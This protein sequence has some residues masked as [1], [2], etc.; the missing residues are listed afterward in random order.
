MNAIREMNLRR[1]GARA[2]AAAILILVA[3]A[4]AAADTVEI[5]NLGISAVGAPVLLDGGRMVMVVPEANEGRDL[6]GDGDLTDTVFHLHEIATG[7]TTNLGLAGRSAVA[8]EGGAVALEIFESRQGVDLNGD[9]DTFDTVIHIHDPATG[10]TT[11]LGIAGGN[12][13]RLDGGLLAF[14]ASESGEGED[15]NGDGDTSDVVVHLHDPA[16]GTTTN[17]GIA[18]STLRALDGGGLAFYADSRVHVHDPATGAT[19]DVGIAAIELVALDDGSVAFAAL[20]SEEG[21]LNGD[22][23]ADDAVPHR[24]DPATAT[25]TNLGV[26]GRFLVALDGGKLM[27]RATESQQGVDWNGD[28]DTDDFVV[29]VHHPGST[30]TTNVGIA[31]ALG[32]DHDTHVPLEQGRLAFWASESRH[33]GDLNGD[34]DSS[35]DV[36]HVHDPSTGITAS[37][38]I[39]SAIFF[40]ASLVGLRG[41]PVAFLASEPGEGTDLNGDG[42]TSDVIAHAYD[43]A[44]GTTANSGTASLGFL[45]LSGGSAAMAVFEGQENLDLNGDG[46]VDDFVPIVFDP[47]TGTTT[48][49]GLAGSALLALPGG[50]FV[51]A[52]VE[53]WEGIDL[54]DDGDL[55]DSVLHIITFAGP[56][57]TEPPI[58]S[59]TA[60]TPNPVAIGA[61]FELTATV[62]DTATGGSIIATAAYS[63]D[64]TGFVAMDASDGAFDEPV[65]DVVAR[66]AELGSAGVRE[67]CVTGS[68]AAGNVSAPDCILLTVYDPDEDRFVT[69]GGWIHSPAGAFLDDPDASGRASFG[70]VSRYQDGSSIPRGQTQFRLTAAGLTFHSTAY[71]WL[72][73]SGTGARYDGTGTVNG[74]QG[75]GFQV[76]ATDGDLAGGDGVDRL[77]LRI[78]NQ[79]SG[80]TVYDSQ[81][82]DDDSAEATTPLG[83]GNVTLHG[84]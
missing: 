14:T 65:E 76:T 12:A 64:G 61:P 32:D 11:N 69:G 3:A 28:G 19:T 47:A 15:L 18:G 27:F 63:I 22:G 84:G 37:T 78:W 5:T 73:I 21:D 8:L 72:V 81:P 45:P 20:E 80:V 67:I 4:A 23:D 17:L 7:F 35:D 6:N 54:N 36:V 46:D 44:T 55:N 10:I 29:H 70:F 34:G 52:A 75:Y 62:D 1:F 60:A 30:G 68:D 71:E 83:G 50:G 43:P 2:A 26:A 74:A 58:V 49:V 40:E 9:G 24:Y 48:N 42:D 66:I 25:I 56:A 77:R 31:L 13:I 41:G 16:T 82:G 39:A 51:M 57:D 59:A 53:S 33:G 38:G 79:S